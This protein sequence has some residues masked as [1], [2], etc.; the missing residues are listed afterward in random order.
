MVAQYK[1]H[2]M[3]LLTQIV[4]V[5]QQQCMVTTAYQQP[6]KQQKATQ[7]LVAGS[8]WCKRGRWLWNGTGPE[9]CWQRA[10]RCAAYV[11]PTFLQQ[12]TGRIHRYTH[13]RLLMTLFFRSAAQ[14]YTLRK[15]DTYCNTKKSLKPKSNQWPEQLVDRRLDDKPS[16]QSGHVFNPEFIQRKI[17]KHLYCA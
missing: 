13:N 9:T 1:Q 10:S 8:P 14:I 3:C 6:G 2:I 12:P 7:E 5:T 16:G 11:S 15:R 17:L 4:K